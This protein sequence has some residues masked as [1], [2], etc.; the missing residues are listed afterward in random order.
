MFFFLG[1]GGGT[2]SKKMKENRGFFSTKL[3]SEDFIR[4]TLKRK[5]MP[6]SLTEKNSEEL[7]PF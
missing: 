1:G 5:V 4:L 3:N 7:K 2:V 6:Y